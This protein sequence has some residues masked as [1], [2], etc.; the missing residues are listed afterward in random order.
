MMNRLFITRLRNFMYF[1]IFMNTAKEIE[2]LSRKFCFVVI[3]S[4]S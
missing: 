2:D 1:Y 3:N 4:L